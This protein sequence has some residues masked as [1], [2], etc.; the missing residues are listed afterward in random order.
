MEIE[1]VDIINLKGP[2][3]INSKNGHAKTP[4]IGVPMG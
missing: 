4:L 2:N 3:L 1:S